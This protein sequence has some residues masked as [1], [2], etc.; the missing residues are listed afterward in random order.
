MKKTYQSSINIGCNSQDEAEA[1]SGAC[2]VTLSYGS[3]SRPRRHG[4]ELAKL[5]Q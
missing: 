1:Y 3:T 4:E 5:R 2:R